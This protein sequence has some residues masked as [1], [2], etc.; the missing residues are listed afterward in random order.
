MAALAVAS[1][2][3][4]GA[5]ASLAGEKLNLAP[6]RTASFAVQMAPV[7]CSTQRKS[8][9]EVVIRQRAI[10]A[11]ASASVM[12][13]ATPALA[14]SD[15]LPLDL[16]SVAWGALMVVFSFSLSLV[17]WGRSGL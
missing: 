2:P 8:D 12:A 14:A 6:A 3:V 10:M 9:S 4:V 11:A 5:C 13:I 16:T 7:R 1:A 17:V 15:S